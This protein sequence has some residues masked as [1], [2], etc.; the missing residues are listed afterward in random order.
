M[1]W[2]GLKVSYGFGGIKSAEYL[3]WSKPG[4]WRVDMCVGERSEDWGTYQMR[5]KYVGSG[6]TEK[7]AMTHGKYLVCRVRIF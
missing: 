4:V 1:C 2:L 6:L 5:V 3:F 7:L